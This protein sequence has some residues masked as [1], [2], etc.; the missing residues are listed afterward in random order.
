MLVLGS[1]LLQEGLEAFSLFLGLTAHQMPKSGLCED[2]D[3]CVVISHVE[4]FSA[5]L[6]IESE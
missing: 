6:L 2:R 3:P 5:D 1:P 4:G